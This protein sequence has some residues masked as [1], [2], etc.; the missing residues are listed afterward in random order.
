[1]V[2][3]EQTLKTV[4]TSSVLTVCSGILSVFTFIVLCVYLLNI[5]VPLRSVENRCNVISGVVQ[6]IVTA[7]SGSE[8]VSM[9]TQLVMMLTSRLVQCKLRGGGGVPESSSVVLCRF[10]NIKLQLIFFSEEKKIEASTV[11]S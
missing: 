10:F 6:T 5:N 4:V 9:T 8:A 11:W 2:W 7:H 1:M 3:C